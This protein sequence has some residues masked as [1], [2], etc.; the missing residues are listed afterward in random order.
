MSCITLLAED[1][2]PTIGVGDAKF[3]FLD[4]S[5]VSSLQTCTVISAGSFVNLD[6]LCSTPMMGR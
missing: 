6:V 3:G 1:R 2:G 4:A 5:K